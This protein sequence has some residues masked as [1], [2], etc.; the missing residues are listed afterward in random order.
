MDDLYFDNFK[1]LKK[2]IKDPTRWSFHAQGWEET[3]LHKYYQ[4]HS[5]NSM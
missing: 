3:I 4:E 5:S 1:M 2:E